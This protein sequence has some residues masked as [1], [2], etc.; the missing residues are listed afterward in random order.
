MG[1]TG[2]ETGHLQPGD[3]V[4]DQDVAAGAPWSG[5]LRQGQVLRIIDLDGQQAVDALFYAL[6]DTSERYSMQDTLLANGSPYL[7]TGTALLSNRGR[8]L[9][10]IVTD[11]CTNHDTVA[12]C[13]SCE[14]NTVRFGHETRYMHACR[15]NFITE[16]AKHGMSKR[17]IVPNVNFFMNVPITPDGELNVTDGVSVP[18]TYVDVRAETDV[19]CVLSNCPQ[20]N[21]PCNG[22]V[23]TP[24]RVVITGAAGTTLAGPTLAYSDR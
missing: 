15:E 9:A 22:Y 12:G 17:D 24:I 1:E 8:T 18:G 3:A 6:P 7:N 10:T 14:S 21:N 16:L 4:Y 2:G 11:T 20:L 19:L 23:P 13:C 5:V